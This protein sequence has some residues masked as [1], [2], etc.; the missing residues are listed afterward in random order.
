MKPG[1][2]TNVIA[3][4]RLRIALVSLGIAGILTAAVLAILQWSAQPEPTIQTLAV[5]LTVEELLPS[6]RTG[7]ARTNEVVTFGIPLRP[8]DNI[9]SIN[10]LGLAGTAAGQFRDIRRRS[11]GT[12]E[13]VLVDTLATVAAGTKN[14]SVA[15]TTGAGNFPA[16]QIATDTSQTIVVNTGPAAFTIRK[17]N[18]NVLD[19]VTVNG[20]TF[21]AGGHSG[22]VWSTDAADTRFTS[23]TS[24][25]T[26]TVEDNGPVRASIKVD[27]T[28]KAGSS[29]HF[30]YTLRMQFVRNSS[31]VTFD[32]TLRNAQQGDLGKKGF[33]A[34]GIAL[35]TTLTANQQFIFPTNAGTFT[36]ALAGQSAYLFQAYA[37]NMIES[38]T[39]IASNLK[40]VVVGTQ[41]GVEVK[42]GPTTLHAL[43]SKTEWSSGWARL[44]NAN[45][46]GPAL[47]VAID[48]LS[49]F[50]PGGFEF[51]ADGT[52]DLQMF[53]PHN[54]AAP[55]YFT[56]GAHDTR[57]LAMDF[58]TSPPAPTDESTLAAV[59]YPLFARA[60]DYAYY[61]STGAI[62]GAD[63]LVTEAE[64]DQFIAAT[65]ASFGQS[66]TARS[67]RDAMLAN[68]NKDTVWRIKSW[69]TT[70]GPNQLDKS[71]T[72][73]LDYLR[74]GK[75][76]FFLRAFAESRYKADQAA[77]HC[78]DC[79]LEATWPSD[80][81]NGWPWG[82]TSNGYNGGGVSGNTYESN[83]NHPH[84]VSLVPAWLLTGDQ[85]FFDDTRETADYMA[86]REE[87]MWG[88]MHRNVT[89]NG[90][91]S[92]GLR[93][94]PNAFRDHALFAE[95]LN[96][97]REWTALRFMADQ[98]I[99][100]RD[101][102]ICGNPEGQ[103]LDRGFLYSQ[104]HQD[105]TVGRGN[106]FY[107][108]HFTP[109]GVWEAM[110]VLGTVSA[111]ATDRTLADQLGQFLLGHAEFVANEVVKYRRAPGNG[112]YDGWRTPYRIS[113]EHP[114]P[115]TIT[116]DPVNLETFHRADYFPAEFSW[117][118]QQTGNSLFL[119]AGQGLFIR[120]LDYE[121][122]ERGSD[123]SSQEFIWD[124]LHRLQFNAGFIQPQAVDLGGGQWQLTWTAPGNV[125][126]YALRSSD[127]TIV[128]NRYYDSD[129]TD[130]AVASYHPF[131]TTVSFWQATPLSGAPAPLPGGSTQT[132]TV[133]VPAGQTHFM[134][135]YRTQTATPSSDTTP[136]QMTNLQPATSVVAGSSF[137]MGLTTNEPATCKYGPTAGEAY[138]LK[139]N[140]FAVT[141]TT[142]QTSVTLP[143]L[144]VGSYQYYVRCKDAAGN[145]TPSDAVLNFTVTPNPSD[146]T[147]PT[148]LN[149]RPFK[150]PY[151]SGTT[152]ASM[153][154]ETDQPA[155]CRYAATAGVSYDA[156]PANQVFTASARGTAH[157]L[158]LD[159]TSGTYTRYVRCSDVHGN[160]N[161]DDVVITLQVS[162]GGGDTTPPVI[163]NVAASNI[164]ATS[165]TITWTTN[166]AADS[167]VEYGL[168]TAYGLETPVNPSMVT[169]HSLILNDLTPTT[170]YHY[171]VHSA[172]ASGNAAAS[173]NA[174]FTTTATSGDT[175]PPVISAVAST[176]ITASG[177]TITWTTDEPADSQ[178]EYGLTTA[179][180]SLTT[181]NPALT[182]GHSQALTGL[183]ANSL[184]HFRVR[185]RDA[186]SNLAVSGDATFTTLTQPG[187]GGW[188][189]KFDFNETAGNHAGGDW[190]NVLI[191]DALYQDG[192]GWG[193]EG[194]SLYGVSA[195]TRTIEP[196]LVWRDFFRRADS[197]SV[198]E[199][200][201]KVRVPEPGDY[202]V[203][204][205]RG[206]PQYTNTFGQPMNV[207][208]GGTLL[209]SVPPPTDTT[210]P[211]EPARATLT[212]TNVTDGF[213]NL[214]FSMNGIC[215]PAADCNWG[216][217]ALEIEQIIPPPTT[218]SD[219]TALNTCSTTM[220]KYCTASGTLVN[221]CGQCGCPQGNVCRA[222]GA[223]VRIS[224]PV[225]KK[226]WWQL[227]F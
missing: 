178:V 136:P 92:G 85:Q 214:V 14:T 53:S 102:G 93:G 54:A 164:T 76:G 135:Q 142:L 167:Q 95:Y 171:R 105:C 223:C 20:Q 163:T 179:Y 131:S 40:P 104:S 158:I 153:L 207:L 59:Q 227:L 211:Y 165:A 161:T 44:V 151:P 173:S 196:D 190:E 66:H 203:S 197:S 127:K 103:N 16:E 111:E 82:D 38:N 222:D 143:T 166:E 224:Q 22:G 89:A 189:Q 62:F 193:F 209:G 61:G 225:E 12:I 117:A 226:P 212:A 112:S 5:P 73:F 137:R 79:D 160:K 130:P 218:C 107:H 26:F 110:R 170:L 55:L 139:P 192:R 11:D 150:S 219:G 51:S 74:T 155:N 52:V 194:T 168:T 200:T 184:Y 204:V 185:S 176:S 134:V 172:D 64:Y 65:D 101:S 99:G 162:G 70:G 198:N 181:L 33:K 35:P 202:L 2:T 80:G 81:P 147:A 213:L 126:A 83:R 216:I 43:G 123:L 141:G 58:Q 186:A 206:D 29:E 1:A 220:P 154:L 32:L 98:L 129:Q 114:N 27:G 75:G 71:V 119:E 182:T 57:T 217:N 9:T 37:E 24:T 120:M 149:P 23:A 132:A 34:V 133:T 63:K 199:R 183:S 221:N 195:R 97:P 208:E 25:P 10:Q 19:S 3:T 174:T 46:A 210:S 88:A 108:Q 115:I 67:E 72:H 47:T 49:E 45:G 100:S 86:Y 191:T 91:G 50:W 13:W 90:F 21:I 188:S 187:G 205:T 69:G 152:K 56:W 106:S 125:V 68:E 156:M 159:V 145:V 118:Y 77:V 148:R 201:F 17:A 116:G 36:G 94:W 140:Y 157:Y 78:D 109:L 138:E 121:P 96:L 18:F 128:E 4:T 215:S 177:A 84:W 39:S 144:F 15:L 28:L 87:G 169:S 60:T 124:W 122:Y 113:F 31:R 175:T 7:W 42:N 41:D 180:G 146:T 30:D 8:S 6:D 48:H